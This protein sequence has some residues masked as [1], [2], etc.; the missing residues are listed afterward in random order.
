ML[1]AKEIKAFLEIGT[2]LGLTGADLRQYVDDA[3]KAT[4][5]EKEKATAFELEKM[6][7][8]AAEKERLAA[9]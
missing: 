2:T 6:K 9:Q 4:I 8:E 7:L 5:I 3:Q 1:S